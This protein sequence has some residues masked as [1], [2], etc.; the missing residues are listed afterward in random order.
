[1]IEFFCPN[2]EKESLDSFAV[3][4]RHG[5]KLKCDFCQQEFLVSIE[6][7]EQM[8]APDGALVVRDSS[9]VLTCSV[10]G[11]GLGVE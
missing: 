9:G 11:T 3:G 2:C 4:L 7:V 1:M 5:R 10:C 8:R 6:A